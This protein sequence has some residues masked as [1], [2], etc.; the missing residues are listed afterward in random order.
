MTMVAHIRGPLKS[1][2]YSSGRHDIAGAGAHP[3]MIKRFYLGAFAILLAGGG[4][5]GLIVLRTAIFV[6]RFH[7]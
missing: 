4:V 7:Y 3:A 1:A 6:W 2:P 5:V